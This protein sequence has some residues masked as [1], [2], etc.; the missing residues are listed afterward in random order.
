LVSSFT[1]PLPIT[2]P[3]IDDN[4]EV[5]GSLTIK[6]YR[7]LFDFIDENKEKA[8]KHYKILYREEV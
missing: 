5:V 4:I 6:T 7:E 3:V 1:K 8:L 2:L